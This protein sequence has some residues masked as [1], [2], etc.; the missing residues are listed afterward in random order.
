MIR[1]DLAALIAT[2]EDHAREIYKTQAELAPLIHV[3][4]PNGEIGVLPF[5]FTSADDRARK[6]HAARGVLKDVEASAYLLLSESWLVE[7][8]E[9]D[10]LSSASYGSFARHPRRVEILMIIAVARTGEKDSAIFELKRGADGLVA[11]L[12]RRIPL[13][14]IEG[15]LTE[16]FDR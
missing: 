9:D 1:V 3:V 15:E 6:V 13:N 11:S 16:L 7:E 8:T 4:G 12:T 5:L 14:P 2:A 10:D